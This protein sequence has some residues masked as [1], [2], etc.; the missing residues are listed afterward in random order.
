MHPWR[1]VAA[2]VKGRTFRGDNARHVPRA[3]DIQRQQGEFGRT[4]SKS[5]FVLLSEV[6][7]TNRYHWG[8]LWLQ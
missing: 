1:G 7:V 3:R 5:Q 8:V 4:T 2:R 6:G